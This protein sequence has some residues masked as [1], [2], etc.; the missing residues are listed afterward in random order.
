MNR[1]HYFQRCI[2]VYN[3]QIYYIQDNYY[4]HNINEKLTNEN[5]KEG[6]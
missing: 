6:M 1:Y 2:Y 3:S 5:S 4:G